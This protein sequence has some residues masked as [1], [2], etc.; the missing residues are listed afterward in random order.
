MRLLFGGDIRAMTIHSDVQSVLSL[1]YTLH[2]T[3]CAADHVHHDLCFASKLMSH[4]VA[5]SCGVTEKAVVTNNQLAGLAPS[6]VAWGIACGGR[7]SWC[8]HFCT[9]QEVLEIRWSPV[10]YERWFR[11]GLSESPRDVQDW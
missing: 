8:L 10:C 3:S 7:W 11:Y 6:A 2:T 5:P 1:R 4:F 9:D